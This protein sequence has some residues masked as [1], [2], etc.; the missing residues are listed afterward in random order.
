MRYEYHFINSA[1]STPK[2]FN[3]LGTEGWKLVSIVGSKCVFIRE[4]LEN[5]DLAQEQNK[6]WQS[7][8]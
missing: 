1:T 5:T 6:W 2:E 7:S 4:L 3:E 8:K